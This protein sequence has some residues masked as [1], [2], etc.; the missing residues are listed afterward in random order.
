M[1][2]TE[3]FSV[4]LNEFRSAAACLNASNFEDAGVVLQTILGRISDEVRSFSNKQSR[5]FVRI[6]EFTSWSYFILRWRDLEPEVPMKALYALSPHSLDFSSGYTRSYVGQCLREAKNYEG[7]PLQPNSDARLA[8]ACLAGLIGGTI[9]MAKHIDV[10][11]SAPRSSTKSPNDLPGFLVSAISRTVPTVETAASNSLW[12][13]R[14]TVP[15]KGQQ[16]AHEWSKH[17]RHAVEADP[18]DF[19]GKTVLIVDDVI[20]TGITMFECARALN[21]AGARSIFGLALTKTFAPLFVGG[22]QH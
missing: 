9:V 14:A 21:A 19:V 18:N 17:F 16:N 1:I 2:A 15:A 11:V 6:E 10:L 7:E 13:R 3:R 22:D 8:L 20:G 5:R 12:K 4:H